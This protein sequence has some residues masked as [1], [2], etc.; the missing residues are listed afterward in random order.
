MN[1]NQVKIIASFLLYKN[2]PRI[3]SY[4][5]EKYINRK[6]LS[7]FHQWADN[8]PC[9]GA[10]LFRN[11]S[12][13]A[14]WII[15]IDWR[16]SDNFYVI[17]FPESKSGPIAEIH[18]IMDKKGELALQWRYSPIKRDNRNKER[19]AYFAEAFLS[20]DVYISIP[21]NLSDVD[22][23]IDELFTLAESRLKADSLDPNRP[24]QRRGFPE[25]KL[26]ERLHY[27]RE[28]DQELVR[29][30]KDLAMEK[31]GRLKCKCC[32]FDFLITYGEIGRGFIE[33]HHTKP[34]SSLHEGGEETKLEDLVM[35]CSNCH[36]MLHRK[37]PWLKMDELSRL[38]VANQRL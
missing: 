38:I 20:N 10:F 25:G 9:E 33:A 1:R 31:D 34:V 30:A 21:K 8:K 37:R 11:V 16:E 12:G 22:G 4:R 19:K 13:Y 7:G 2:I 32:G 3:T 28:R 26:K 5:R 18:K 17:I 23:F 14:L 24:N 35:V 27:V 15:L 36:E 29:Q 6:N